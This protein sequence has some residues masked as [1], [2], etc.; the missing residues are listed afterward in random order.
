VAEYMAIA[1]DLLE[2]SSPSDYQKA[3]QLAWKL[4]LWVP[5]DVY[6]TMAQALI[7]PDLN[8]N[9]LYVVVAG[10]KILLGDSSGNR[11][12]DQ[13]LVHKPGIGKVNV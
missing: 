13:I 2:S 10:R 6:K 8:T 11:T 5:K 7:H 12:K 4:A 1:N 3:N 9:L